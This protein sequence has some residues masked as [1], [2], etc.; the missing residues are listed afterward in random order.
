MPA[1]GGVVAEVEADADDL[2]RPR[3]RRA[4]AACRRRARRRRRRRRATQS[5]EAAQAV[6]AEEG[7]VVVAAEGRGVDARAV[8]EQHG[9]RSRR[10]ALAVIA[11]ASYAGHSAVDGIGLPGDE[12]GFVRAEIE[13]ELRRPPRAR[14][15]GRSAGSRRAA[16]TSPA[17]GPDS[18]LGQEPV[19]ERRV[20]ARRADA[21]A[22]DAAASCSRRRSSAS[23][24]AR[25]PW[26]S[27]R[28]SGRGCRRAPRS[29]HV[30]DHAAALRAACIGTAALRAEVDAHDVDAVEAVEVVLGRG[31]DGA[32]V[33]DAGVVD[34][35]VEP[36]SAAASAR[37]ARSTASGC[38]RRSAWRRGAAGAVIAAATSGG[39]RPRRDRRRPRARRGRRRPARWPPRSRA[40]PGHHGHLSL[41]IE[42][43]PAPGIFHE[44]LDGVKANHS[45]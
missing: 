20:D 37:R 42:H 15:C 29:S 35:D 33:G 16:R 31:L 10:P 25:R 1:L 34:Q 30:E 27:S 9:R 14:P 3:E 23:S 17:R 40:R 22:A 13:R 18:W 21:V 8:V 12:R 2:A 5:R 28:R 4:E 32:D 6:A 45:L 43:V 41:E 26:S 44:S 24:S 36:R 7:L 11:R 38:E 39:R 19:D